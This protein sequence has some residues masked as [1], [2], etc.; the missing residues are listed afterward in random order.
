MCCLSWNSSSSS[1]CLGITPADFHYHSDY[2]LQHPLLSAELVVTGQSSSQDINTC[3][4]G[5]SQL[6]HPRI[7]PSGL[8]SFADD[9]DTEGAGSRK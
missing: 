4:A 2:L 6:D 1:Q 3:E 5:S 7:L 8:V 9:L